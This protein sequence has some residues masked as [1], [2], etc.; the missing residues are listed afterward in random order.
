M[1]LRTAPVVGGVAGAPRRARPPL[2]PRRAHFTVLLQGPDKLVA[3]RVDALLVALF[4]LH[5]LAPCLFEWLW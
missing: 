5:A 4:G 3:D 1:V 2:V